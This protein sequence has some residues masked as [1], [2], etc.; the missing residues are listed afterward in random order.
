MLAV[1]SLALD[2]G[3]TLQVRVANTTN[4]APLWMDSV[5]VAQGLTLNSNAVNLTP[6]G[7]NLV[8][9]VY[10]L[11]SY[12]GLKTGSLGIV[13]HKTR[14]TITADESTTNQINLRSEEH[15]P[16]LQS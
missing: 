1:G 15:T 14:Y 16:E 11:I 13:I 4:S 8:P 7:T 6:L 3:A 10:R 12:A 5:T 9:G 2:P